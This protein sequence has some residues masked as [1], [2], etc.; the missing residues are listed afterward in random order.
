MQENSLMDIGIAYRIVSLKNMMLTQ[1]ATLY[2]R[3]IIPGKK[4]EIQHICPLG[5]PL[6]IA[7]DQQTLAISRQLW[8]GFELEEWGK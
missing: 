6:I 5:D 1:R 2:S 4:V 3:G 8:A 7:I